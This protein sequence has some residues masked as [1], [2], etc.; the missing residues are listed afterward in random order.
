MTVTVCVILKTVGPVLSPKSIVAD[1]G[2]VGMLVPL[3][4]SWN[5]TFAEEKEWAT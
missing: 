5:V 4:V 2:L 1:T 3:N